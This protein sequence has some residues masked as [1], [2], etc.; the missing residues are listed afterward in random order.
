MGMIL[1]AR[2]QTLNLDERP[3]NKLL[4][5]QLSQVNL[6]RKSGAWGWRLPLSLLGPY[7]R[8]MP[9]PPAPLHDTFDSP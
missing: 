1:S 3:D 6:F 7:W 9:W 2:S 5:L 8:A 4:Q